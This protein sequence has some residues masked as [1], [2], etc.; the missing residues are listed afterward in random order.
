MTSTSITL[1]LSHKDLLHPVREWLDNIEIHNSKLA[2]LLCKAIP[3]QCP[4]ERDVFL[5][6]R[7][8]FHIPAMCK[9][10]P[11]YEQLVSLRF[12]SLCYLADECGEDVTVYC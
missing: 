3:A 7:K 12:K 10:N 9:L 8:L 4:F 2:H 5:F 1:Q 11:L 6:G